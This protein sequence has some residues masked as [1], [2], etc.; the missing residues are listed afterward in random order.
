[1]ISHLKQ[2]ASLI[3]QLHALRFS[4]GMIVLAWSLL[5]WGSGG[6]GEGAMLTQS[7][8]EDGENAPWETFVTPNGTVGGAGW[9]TLVSFELAQP[10]APS[11]ALQFKV[12]Q[13]RYDPENEPEQGGGVVA[14]ITTESGKLQLSAHIAVTYHSPKDKRNLAGGLF[15]WIV[16]DQVIASHDMGP[17]E[18][19]AIL[20]HH[21]QASCDVNAGVHSI[22]LRITRP[23]TSTPGQD[24]PFQYVDD[25]LI[26][27]ASSP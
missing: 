27:H 24:A 12:G 8:F 21:L 20:R 4:R 3:Q 11:K 10:G 22:R 25:L 19:H 18:N 13:V 6:I 23:F 14:Q 15:E 9:P 7:T 16:D 26:R 2:S 1:M 5:L 17:I